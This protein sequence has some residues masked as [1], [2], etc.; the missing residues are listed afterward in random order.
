[1]NP[2]SPLR[3]S[4]RPD[5]DMIEV[6]T[7]GPARTPD[8]RA[9]VRW[10]KYGSYSGW[11]AVG[12]RK[13]KLSGQPKFWEA[14][15]SVACAC[16]GGNVDQA[17]CCGRGILALGGLGVTMRSGY[18]Q[19]LLHCCLLKN[20]VRYVEI[21]APVI[22]ATSSYTKA[23]EK[24]PSGVAFHDSM[25][26]PWWTE[27]DL[28]N[29][30]TLGSD[31]TKWTKPQKERA[32]TWVSC[33]SRLLRDEAMDSAQQAFAEEVMPAL[34]TEDTKTAINW[35][36]QGPQDF[37]QF[38]KEQQLL[39]GL[40][41]VLALE[42]E[43]ETESLMVGARSLADA[44]E[45]FSAENMFRQL[46]VKL[47]LGNYEQTFRNRFSAGIALLSKLMNVELVT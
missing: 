37:W 29:L 40:A 10:A 23:S 45:G 28:R 22:G 4:V 43:K 38:T 2:R 11:Y 27:T 26:G 46:G 25:G 12:A 14:V 41:C 13:P 3:V 24:S 36:R 7:D 32:K 17:H 42:D 8:G 6:T 31:G 33:C 5:F 1:M 19:L 35:P 18:A 16:A 44:K 15:F 39:W 34:L 9:W 30:V 47:C 21:M 20:P